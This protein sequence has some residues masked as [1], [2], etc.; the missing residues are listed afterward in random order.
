[1]ILFKTNKKN[2]Q[3]KRPCAKPFDYTVLGSYFM[4]INDMLTKLILKMYST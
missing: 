1:M 2:K 3:K 4:K